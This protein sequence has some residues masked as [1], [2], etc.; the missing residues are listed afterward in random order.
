MLKWNLHYFWFLF[1]LGLRIQTL[2]P[3]LL[4]LNIQI[5][6][7]L[8]YVL[9]NCINDLLF[10]NFV[11]QLLLHCINFTFVMIFIFIHSQ[12]YVTREILA[13]LLHLDSLI[14][15]NILHNLYIIIDIILKIYC[16]P[17]QFLKEKFSQITLS[18]IKIKCL[19]FLLKFKFKVV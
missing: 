10:I 16:F 7:E 12:A 3:H 8:C 19:Q 11:V 15:D 9:S 13:Q 2:G 4:Q 6:F 18:K 17:I 1:D 5:C 14:I